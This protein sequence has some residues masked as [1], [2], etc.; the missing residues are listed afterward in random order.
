MTIHE[1]KKVRKKEKNDVNEKK[2][3][4]KERSLISEPFMRHCSIFVIVAAFPIMIIIM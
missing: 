4:G 1:R 3:H 2:R